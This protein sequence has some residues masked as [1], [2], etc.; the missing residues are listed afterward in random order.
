MVVKPATQQTPIP[1]C[2][3]QLLL[4]P[5]HMSLGVRLIR[6]VPGSAAGSGQPPAASVHNHASPP[7]VAPLQPVSSP[8]VVGSPLPFQLW[9]KAILEGIF[10]NSSNWLGRKGG[11]GFQCHSQRQ[12]E[13]KAGKGYTHLFLMNKYKENRKKKYPS[14]R[15]QK[16]SPHCI[17][18]NCEI[19]NK[20]HR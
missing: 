1:V 8:P 17:Q 6:A 20:R 13:L 4:A 7:A 18:Y 16:E 9:P 19:M 10:A 12:K 2:L 14:Q 3:L 15:L 5:A 11:S